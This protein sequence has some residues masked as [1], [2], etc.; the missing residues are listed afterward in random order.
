MERVACVGTS[1]VSCDILVPIAELAFRHFR[2]WC[3]SNLE[4]LL[5]LVLM[6]IT[7]PAFSF[8]CYHVLRCHL[9]W[10]QFLQHVQVS[11]RDQSCFWNT[12]VSKM[13]PPRL[14]FALSSILIQ[15]DWPFLGSLPP[16]SKI[17]WLGLPAPICCLQH[18]KGNVLVEHGTFDCSIRI[19]DLPRSWRLLGDW[20]SR[21]PST[22][23]LWNPLF[24]IFG[25]W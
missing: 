10:H 8:R 6:I 7:V 14:Q 1:F 16:R 12:M 9:L 25:G 22:N 23:G 24:H 17:I 3:Q 11:Y 21:L 19:L 20:R 13:Q 2:S 15:F 5:I 4:V 18:A